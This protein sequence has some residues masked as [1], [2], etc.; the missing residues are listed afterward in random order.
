MFVSETRALRRSHSL[1]QHTKFLKNNMIAENDLL[2]NFDTI[3]RAKVS[4]HPTRS[5]LA[6]FARF[7]L[8]AHENFRKKSMSQSTRNDLRAMQKK[9]FYPFDLLFASRIAPSPSGV[10][11]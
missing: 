11:L 5:H 7:T 1:S 9:K 10:A 2:G 6:R 4:T 8:L 3:Y